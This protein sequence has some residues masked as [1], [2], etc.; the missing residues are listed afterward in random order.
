MT[1]PRYLIRYTGPDG[2]V[3]EFA[4]NPAAARL[5]VIAL[6]NSGIPKPSVWREVVVDIDTLKVY[7][8]P[9]AHDSLSGLVDSYRDDGVRR[10][11]HHPPTVP[12][13]TPGHCP[14]CGSR[15]LA[16]DPHAFARW[17]CNI[18]SHTW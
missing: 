12:G 2:L 13:T 4:D 1:T 3:D 14:L 17:V 16:Q 18:C 8:L 11:G 5:R 6:M 15:S 7:E 9:P 10:L